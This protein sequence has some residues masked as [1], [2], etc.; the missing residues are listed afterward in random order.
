MEQRANPR[1]TSDPTRDVHEVLVPCL[2]LLRAKYSSLTEAECRV[3]NY[4]LGDPSAVLRASVI[5]IAQASGVGSGSVIRMCVKLGYSGF[6][7]MKVALA[8]QLLTPEYTIHESLRADDDTATVIRKSLHLAAQNL[9]DTATLL[10]PTELERASDAIIRAGRIDV[11]AVNAFSAAIA[12]TAHARFALL[13]LPSALITEPW[14]QPGAASRL[15][16]G[17]VAVAISHSG[18]TDSLVNALANASEAHATAICLTSNPHTPLAQAAQIR[19][20]VASQDPSIWGHAAASRIALY[21]AI[22]TLYTYISL[23]KYRRQD[24]HPVLGEI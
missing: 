4:I 6:A 12:Q 8:A 1:I 11:Y 24:T 14:Q 3:A 5:E 2:V 13:D 17:D 18:T 10:D 21:G 15:R 19:L 22:E 7:A 16:A 20:I 9:T 23:A